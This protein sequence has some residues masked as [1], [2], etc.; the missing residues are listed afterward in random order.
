MQRGARLARRDERE[1]GFL[2]VA[3]IV[4]IFLILLALSVAAPRLAMQMK[5]QKEEETVHRANQYV[6]A[7]QLYYRKFGTY[8]PSI[9]AL[10]KSNNQRFLRQEY[11]DPL[12]GKVDWKIIKVGANKTKVKGFFGEDLPGLPGGLGAAAGLSSGTSGGSTAVGGTAIVGASNTPG[13]SGTG[14]GGG[15]TGT[16]GTTANTGT[17]TPGTSSGLG[18][19]PTSQDATTASLG[20]VGPI[21]G[22]SVGKDGSSIIVVNEQSQYQ[23]W[24]FLYD[25]RIEAM[26]AKASLLGG[27]ATGGTS[28][29]LGS[30]NTLASPT[31]NTPPTSNGLGSGTN[32]TTPTTSPT[33]PP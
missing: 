3:L 12:T 14:L 29:G 10:K 11:L 4:A 20:Q 1:D 25:P 19:G 30:A 17:G 2:L 21:M 26:K 32:S 33:T 16:T 24:E 13:S 18:S 28:G 27:G 8:P 15:T 31:G 5:R 6:R 22:V 9:D 7:I 23:D